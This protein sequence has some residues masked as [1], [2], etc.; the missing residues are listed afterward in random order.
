MLLKHLTLPPA[1]RYLDVMLNIYNLFF[2]QVYPTELEFNK[3]DSFDS[4]APFWTW[5]ANNE[6][7]SDACILYLCL[8]IYLSVCPSVC[9]SLSLSLSAYVV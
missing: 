7:I 4:V 6:W 8:S 3:V 9:L 1:S 5:I 2:V